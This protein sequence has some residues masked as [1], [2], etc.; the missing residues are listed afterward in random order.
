[1]LR[2]YE[3]QL[4]TNLD[5]AGTV[6]ASFKITADGSVYSANAYGVDDDLADCVANILSSIQFPPTKGGG[7]VQ[8]SSFPITFGHDK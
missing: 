6:N 1:M 5:L 3:E 7:I 4:A 8:V 2:C